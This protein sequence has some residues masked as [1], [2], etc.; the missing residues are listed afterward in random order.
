MRLHYIEEGSGKPMV[1]LHGNGEDGSYF[2]KQIRH[3]AK[4]YHVYA[5]DTRGHGGSPRGTGP[6]TLKRFAA[7]LKEFLDGKELRDIILLGFSDG[8]NIALIFALMYPGYVGQ[9]V[10]NGA[11]LNP[12]GMKPLVLAQV[13]AGYLRASLEAVMGETAMGETA[14]G[15]TAAGKTAAGKSKYSPAGKRELYGLMLKEPWIRPEHLRELQVPVLVLAG[16]R[17]MIRERHT[18]RIH[19]LIPGSRLKLVRGDHF[20]AASNARDFNRAVEHFLISTEK[21]D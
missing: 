6:F 7:D 2:K 13:T 14:A 4:N 11:N 19:R 17:D 18:R 3:F 16:T 20:I 15:K 5:V 9:L 10:L 21:L 8:G 1:L 12:F